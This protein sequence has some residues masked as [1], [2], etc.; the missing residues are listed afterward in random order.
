MNTKKI[1]YEDSEI[2][3]WRSRIV[4][5]K[6]DNSLIIMGFDET[7]F[8]PEGGGQPCDKGIV[9]GNGWKVYIEYVYEENGLIWHK[10]KL[11]GEINPQIGEEVV[12][13]VDEDLRREYME[14]HTAQH[15]LSAIIE[16]GYSLETTGFQILDDHTKIEIPYD[17][18]N[19]ETFIR[20]VE[21][22]VNN[23]IKRDLPLKIYWAD[24][25]TRIVEIPELD[26]NPCGG[27]HVKKL[28]D[29]G[30]LKITDFYKKNNNYWRVEFVAGRRILKRLE[31]REREYRYCKEKLG[32]SNIIEG[33]DKILSKLETLE[34][35]NKRLREELNIY[36]AY[37][38]LDN[39]KFCNCGRLVLDI[40]DKDI[41]DVKYI[42]QKILE[43]PKVLGMLFNK[44]GQGIVF[45][46]SEVENNTFQKIIEILI[47]N[48]WRGSK[49]GFFLQG[50]IDDP[51]SI[52]MKVME[53][54]KKNFNK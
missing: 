12:L 8:Y 14:Q 52:I 20:E 4:D 50:K 29:L 26:V 19:P 43:H 1:Y 41:N 31:K 33:I 37:K 32:N 15:L 27:L 44:Q 21:S 9:R 51:H 35:E 24:R 16:R 47:E 22:K 18:D 49:E 5:L 45:R 2:L 34:K 6:R 39:S 46:S 25:N 11:E 42:A 17:G 7:I 10:G 36:V 53:S 23:Y 54:I 48:G 38:L 13:L 3:S 40:L 30:L 28:G